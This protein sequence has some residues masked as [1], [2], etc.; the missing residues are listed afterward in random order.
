MTHKLPD[1]SVIVCAFNHDKWLERCI[2]SLNH[3]EFVDQDVY[4]IIIVDDGSTDNTSEV[5]RNLNGIENVRI[6][7]NESNTGL[8]Q[9]LNMAIRKALGRYV[10]RVD[11]DDYVSRTF[12][13]LMRLFLDMNRHY[14]A[15]ATDYVV[16]D[17]FENL[18]RRE[19]CFSN[20]IACGVM[21]RKECLF[22]IGLYDESFLMR[23]GHDLKRRF[24]D[25]F[26]VARLEYP[27][28]KYRQHSNNRTKDKE[29]IEKYDEKLRRDD[30]RSPKP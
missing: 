8:P 25:L 30:G 3:Q 27:L 18:V 7:K 12:L 22:E 17:Q 2:R 19:N 9:S 15:V 24:E 23:E 6:F 13:Y 5:L 26:S 21:F 14:Q 29:E 28:Y 20:E 10:V 16:V 11:S 1:I 4:E